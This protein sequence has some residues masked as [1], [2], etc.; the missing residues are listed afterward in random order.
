[1]IRWNTDSG[2]L[3]LY[4]A[5]WAPLTT[6][7]VVETFSYTGNVQTWNRPSG[8]NQ[9]VAYMWGA[10]GG[11]GNPGGGGLGGAGGYTAGVIDVTGVGSLFVVVG[12]GGASEENYF[13]NDNGN[14]CGGGVTGI[15][16]VWNT[17]DLNATHAGSVLL[18]GA[19]GA[20]GNT[21]SPGG[22]CGG[23]L[24]GGNGGPAGAS[25]GN[26]GTQS[27]G[28]SYTNNGN[29]SCTAGSACTPTALRGGVGCGG[30]EFAGGS[31]WPNEVW[32][33]VWAAGAGGNG[34]NAAGGGGGYY[35]GSGGGGSPNGGHGAGGSGYIGGNATCQ[36]LSGTTVASGSNH[37]IAPPNTG[38]PYYQTNIGRGG[39]STNTNGYNGLVVIVYQQ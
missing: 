26:G 7:T 8:V 5:A 32:G 34:C 25:D 33:G 3:E 19:G 17:G 23:G 11:H 28:G 27:A 2:E 38:N 35:G 15:F 37:A 24:T 20:G 30:G 4:D 36:V 9:V 10:G 29:G 13:N 14:G 21:G 39:P 22:G 12:E 31:G 16:T 18:A 6:S 1:M